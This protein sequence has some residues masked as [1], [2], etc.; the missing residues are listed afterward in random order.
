MSRIFLSDKLDSTAVLMSSCETEYTHVPS[1]NPCFIAK[2]RGF[3]T[4]FLVFGG[5]LLVRIELI[6]EQN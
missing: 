3:L 1:F 6:A 5:G 2:M 4:S